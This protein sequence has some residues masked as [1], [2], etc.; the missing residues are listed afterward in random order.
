MPLEHVQAEQKVHVL[1]LLQHGDGTREVFVSH[2]DGRLVHAADDLLRAHALR[3]SLP[4]RVDESLQTQTLRAP[5]GHDRHLRPAVDESLEGVAVHLHVHVQHDH[6]AERLRGVLHRLFV[7]FVDVALV[8]HRLDLRL[9][10][11]VERVRVEQVNLRFLPRL[12]F[13]FTLMKSAQDLLELRLVLAHDRAV[14]LRKHAGDLREL[15]GISFE[16]PDVL[17]R[18]H[19]GTVA[20]VHRGRVTRT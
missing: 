19:R 14:Q 17:H 10:L 13:Q 18:V 2:L 9:S 12:F 5:E 11:H 6:A 3:H 1:L 15:R 16:V 20:R 8:N 4:P 7:V